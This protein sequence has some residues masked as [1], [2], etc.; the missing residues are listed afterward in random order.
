LVFLL[1]ALSANADSEIYKCVDADGNVAYQQTPCPVVKEVADGLEAVE[2][3]E[4]VETVETVEVAEELPQ[5]PASSNLTQ[6]E[7]EAC[8][9][10]L[11][12]EIDEI[13]AEMLR[14]FAAEQ[15]EA[16]KVK[17]RTLTQEM[18]ACG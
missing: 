2:A 9:D 5:P 17:L 8:K 12:D 4:A 7:V 3:V 1:A 11:R 10:P 18:R 14:G 16:F 6:E 15:G 13:E